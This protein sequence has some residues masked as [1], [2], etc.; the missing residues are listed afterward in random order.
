[1]QIRTTRRE[2][3]GGAAAAIVSLRTAAAVTTPTT[4]SEDLKL[5]VASYSF[6]KLSRADAIKG[7]KALKVQYINIKDVHLALKST[8]EEIAA[9]RKDFEDAGIK[10][11]GIGNVTFSKPDESE[12][13][14]NFEYAK[15]L[16]APLIVMAPTMETLPSIEKLVKEYNIKAAIHNHGPEDKHFPSPESV[17]SAVKSMDPRMGLC[18]DIGHS[19]RAGSDIVAAAIA[20]GPR[21]HDMHTKDLANLSDKASQ[22]PVGEGAIPI[23]ALFKQLKKMNYKGGVM[24]EFEVDADNPLPGMQKSFSYMHGVLDGLKG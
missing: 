6:R 22:V 21:L 13:K 14:R 12:M 7:M 20:A 10:I 16:G 11:L 19:V 2:I 24:L 8:P 18:M 15:Q 3:I 17:L 5:G 1:M 4:H 23:V 9:A